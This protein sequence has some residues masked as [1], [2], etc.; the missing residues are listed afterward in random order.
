MLDRLNNTGKF[1]DEIEEKDLQ[2]LVRENASSLNFDDESI[3]IMSDADILY[4]YQFSLAKLKELYK[5]RFLTSEECKQLILELNN[6]MIE[7]RFLQMAGFIDK[8]E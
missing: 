8:N 5:E 3:N 2:N 4:V 6:S 1:G 7:F